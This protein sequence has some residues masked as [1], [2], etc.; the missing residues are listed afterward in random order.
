MIVAPHHP[1]MQRADRRPSS[2]RPPIRRT[3]PR[4]TNPTQPNGPSIDLLDRSP[5]PNPRPAPRIGGT[6]RT[7]GEAHTI[8][9]SPS[10][11]HPHA[12]RLG[13]HSAE[14]R[15]P[16]HLRTR[17]RVCATPCCGA[18]SSGGSV[19]QKKAGASGFGA[20]TPNI[21][22]VSSG[23]NDTLVAASGEKGAIFALPLPLPTHTS[24]LPAEG[25]GRHAASDPK[26]AA[27]CVTLEGHIQGCLRAGPL[28]V[29]APVP[30]GLTLRPCL[31]RPSGRTAPSLQPPALMDDPGAF[32]RD[33]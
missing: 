6:N 13:S 3:A 2:L 15:T 29:P 26:D 24:A 22:R 7:S 4:P 21:V 17:A 14:P 5:T 10:H 1:R 31:A 23:M 9:P 19:G 32:L 20:D 25:H 11:L 8:T 18:S 30:S 28:P 12:Q 27:C 16:E 33:R